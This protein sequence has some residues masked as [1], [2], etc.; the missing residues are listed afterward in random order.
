MAG[1]NGQSTNPIISYQ[2]FQNA[3]V[4]LLARTFLLNFGLHYAKR[5]WAAGSAAQQAE[6]VRLCCTIKP[7][8]TWHGANTA[9][10]AR[11]RCGGQGYLSV[12]RIEQVIGFAHAGITAEVRVVIIDA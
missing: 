7:L 10:V 3:L 6:V 1:E 2:L 5:R 11:E 8:I 12:N 4:P 9:S